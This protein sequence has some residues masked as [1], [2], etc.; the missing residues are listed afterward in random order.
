MRRL[1]IKVCGMREADNIREVEALH[2]DYMGFICWPGSRRYV[3]RRPDYLPAACHRTGVFVN[4][5]IR[6]VAEQADLLGLD[7]IQLH[8]HETPEFCREV[9]RLRGRDGQPLTLIK[10]FGVSPGQPLPRTA[11]YEEACDC[12]LFDTSCPTAGGS[13][14][15]FDWGAL[16]AYD[17][18]TPFFLSGG[19]GPDSLEALRHF[20]HPCWTG[21]DLNSRFELSPALKDVERLARFMKAFKEQNHTN[22]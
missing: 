4:P 1:L 18:H 21:V 8:G 14:R 13:G 7:T 3:G 12:F 17:G 10:A 15:T 19:I 6:Q 20:A 11:P 2:P 16:A 9:K 5:D 22:D